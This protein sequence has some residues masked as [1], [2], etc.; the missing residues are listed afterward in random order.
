MWRRAH[1][2]GIFT[3][4]FPIQPFAGPRARSSNNHRRGSSWQTAV[5][6]SFCLGDPL[7]PLLNFFPSAFLAI[8]LLV[9]GAVNA[10]QAGT[11]APA[12]EKAKATKGSAATP[13][14]AEIADAKSKGLVWVNLNTHVYHKDGSFYGTTKNGKFMTEDEATK[15]G[16]RAAKEPGT[17]KKTVPSK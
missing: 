4:N 11:T 16:N 1:P 13:S 15:A 2:A 17:K 3:S 9:P 12:S 10:T 14:A 5:V 6:R 8:A 7:K